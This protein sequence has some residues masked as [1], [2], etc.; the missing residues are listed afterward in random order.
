MLTEKKT[1]FYM[2]YFGCYIQ[3]NTK[4]NPFLFRY[5]IKIITYRYTVID[6]YS[7]EY[8]W[9]RLRIQFDLLE[10]FKSSSEMVFLGLNL[11]K[12]M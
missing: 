6:F 3:L 8:I 9:F 12:I 5:A 4:K 2:A 10:L 7:I 11:E 1:L